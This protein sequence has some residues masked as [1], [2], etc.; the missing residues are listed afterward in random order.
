MKTLS[1]VVYSALRAKNASVFVLVGDGY[2]NLTGKPNL[3]M[4]NNGTE[5]FVVVVSDRRFVLSRAQIEYDSPNYFTDYFLNEHGKAIHDRLE[6]NRDPDI[7]ELVLRYL[8][9]YQV[10]PFSRELAP[11]VSSPERTRADLQADAEFFKLE[12]LMELCGANNSEPEYI[13]MTTY[14]EDDS[15]SLRPVDSMMSLALRSSLE[16][17]DKNTFE[18]VSNG[19]ITHMNS[20][21]HMEKNLILSGWLNMVLERYFHDYHKYVV[22]RWELQVVVL[23]LRFVTF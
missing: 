9:G 7:F 2:E 3:H 8:N 15:G 19:M 5:R 6:I 23:I 14:S 1:S 21:A 20:N 12:G 22:H 17:Y 13:V 4:K 16:T 10:I 18:A 11:I